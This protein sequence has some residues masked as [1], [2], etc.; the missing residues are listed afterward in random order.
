MR[1]P[2]RAPAGHGDPDDPATV[3]G[4]LINQR[5]ADR[6]A[7]LVDD[8]TARGARLLLG[9][10]APEAR[11]CPPTV[12]AGITP[13]MRIYHEE[14]FGPVASLYTVQTDDEAIALANDTAYGLTSAVFTGD[15]TR[16]LA[17]TRQLRHGSAHV[18]NHTIMEEPYAPMGG[19]NDSG[20]GTFGGPGEIDFFTD[21]RW[22]TL[23][24]Q[25]EPLPF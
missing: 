3:V 13:E 8:A 2:R 16:G 25:A 23:S 20:F 6:V 17:I 11:V 19:L 14:T 24:E 9:G 7:A 15:G 4:P 22:I 21:T 5:A 12:L 1:F 18:N 10:G